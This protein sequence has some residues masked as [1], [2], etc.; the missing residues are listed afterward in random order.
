MLLSPPT[1]TGIILAGGKARRMGGEDKGLIHYQQQPL[2]QH[3]INALSPQVDSLVINANRNSEQYAAF[4]HPVISDELSDFQGPLAGMLTALRH[5]DTDYILTAPC[6]TPNLPLQLRQ[7]LMESLLLNQADIA[8]AH[9][10]KRLQ[11]VFCLIPRRLTDSLAAYLESGE[12]KIDRWLQQHKLVEVDFS[13][14]VDSFININT[15]EDLKYAA[16]HNFPL[17]ILGFAAFSG[18]GKTTLLTELIPLLSENG[19]RVGMIK[20]AHHSFEIDQPGKDSYRL[21]QAGAQQMLISSRFQLALMQTARDPEQEAEL[22]T[23]LQRLD[24]SQLDIILVEGFKLTEIPKIELHRPSLGHPFLYPDDP[25]I[26]AIATD[27]TGDAELNPTP[28]LPQLPLND[29]AAI[30]DFIKSHFN[31]DI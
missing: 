15:P 31:Y 20:H 22:S 3:T 8:V 27:I 30:A 25:N 29:P 1:I 10:G 13:D 5:V 21:R 16:P 6:D 18:T 4:G 7:R 17:P 9:D 12:R 26:I 11:P 19:K 2:I 14:Q 24:L 28:K 23:L